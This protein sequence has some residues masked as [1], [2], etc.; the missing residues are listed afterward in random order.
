MRE[1]I[2]NAPHIKVSVKT[3]RALLEDAGQVYTYT[4]EESPYPE[5]DGLRCLFYGGAIFIEVA[6]LKEFE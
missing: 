3:F 6:D 1:Q 5:G 2:A 4:E